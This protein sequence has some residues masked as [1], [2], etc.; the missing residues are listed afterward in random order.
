MGGC[1]NSV[2]GGCTEDYIGTTLGVIEGDARSLD[3]G[4]HGESTMPALR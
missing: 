3:N 2:K 4:S 1:L